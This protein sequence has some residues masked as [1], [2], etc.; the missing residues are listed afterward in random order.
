MDPNHRKVSIV[1]VERNDNVL[2][3]DGSDENIR[4]MFIANPQMT[5]EAKEAAQTEK[6]MSL[7]QAIRLYPKAAGWSILLSTSIVMEGYD[8]ALLGNFYAFLP[9]TK[10]YGVLVPGSN[11]PNYQ[12][13]PSWQ[14]GLSNGAQVGEILGLYGAG[15]VVDKIGYRK[16]MLISL[17]S[18]IC[19][20]F[21]PFFAQNLQTLLVGEIL[22]GIPWGVFQTMTTAYASEVAP[23]VLRPYLTT[24]VNLCWVMGQFIASGVLR[25]F[26]THTDQ[27]AYR[28]PFAIQWMWPLPIFIGCIF[29]PES[30]W[31]YV[32]KGRIEEAK[33]SLIRLTTAKADPNF[34]A[35][36][37]VAMMIHTNELE[38]QIQAGT[39]YLDCFR[40]VD[41]RR[42]EIVSMTWVIQAL[43]GSAFMGFSTYFYENAGLAQTNS[44]DLNMAQYALG[45]IGTIG[46]WFVMVHLGRRTL[47]VWGLFVM[48]CLLLI[49]GFVG[50]A[51]SSNTSASWAVGSMLLVYT[52][53]YDLTVG[54]VC[55]SLVAEISSTRLKAKTIVLARN[56]YNI[57]GIINNVIVPRMLNP[58]AW[59]WGAKAGFFWAGLCF[60]CLT[61]TYFRL[62]E[63]KG[64]TYG[65]LDVLFERKVPARKFKSTIVDQFAGDNDSNGEQEA[66]EEKRAVQHAENISL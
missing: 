44:F 21:I 40:G 12:I 39:G 11:P 52:F 55:Y 43:C 58:L 63:P 47:Y 19:F 42:T 31:W 32:R 61:W 23:V 15:I 25:S 4:K 28:V 6:N 62:P 3:G 46:S 7:I 45:F 17:F 57:A 34:N 22:Q 37:T 2:L 41:A 36:D 49:I 53:V 5:S 59:N 1:S 60:L 24:Y 20:I 48:C 35:D 10:R 14:N 33:R 30:P 54:P 16:T 66:Y 9:F 51:P 18:M 26:L 38:K 65:E 27:W 8:T 64:R 56:F 13:T 50:I 29:A